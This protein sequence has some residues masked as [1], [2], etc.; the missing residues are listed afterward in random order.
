MN[1]VPAN[2]V[3]PTDVTKAINIYR[4]AILVWGWSVYVVDR[5]VQDLVVMGML[6]G[7]DAAAIKAMNDI[8]LE[9]IVM[10][11]CMMCEYPRL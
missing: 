1:S 11:G 7:V 6:H 2:G 10:T 4:L 3:A 5:I 9:R 8:A